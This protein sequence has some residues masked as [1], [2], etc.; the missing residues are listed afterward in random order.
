[1]RVAVDIYRLGHSAVDQLFQVLW[2]AGNNAA[3]VILHELLVYRFFQQFRT[4][5]AGVLHIRKVLG[6]HVRY[7]FEL[8]GSKPHVLD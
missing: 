1:M 4:A 8:M 7:L 2:A 5:V 3:W 6:N